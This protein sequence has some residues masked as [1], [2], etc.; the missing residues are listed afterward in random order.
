[1]DAAERVDL[2]HVADAWRRRARL[3]ELIWATALDD[4]RARDDYPPAT[5][6]AMAFDATLTVDTAAL[7]AS[8]DDARPIPERI[9]D[10]RI[11]AVRAAMHRNERR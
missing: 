5:A 10:A 7:A 2:L 4:D 11:T 1:M 3:D 9:R 8:K 6:L